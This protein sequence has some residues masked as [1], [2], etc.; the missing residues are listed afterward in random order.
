MNKNGTQSSAEQGA[1]SLFEQKLCFVR[2][3][4][5]VQKIALL[6]AVPK[7]ALELCRL[8]LSPGGRR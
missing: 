6:V 7:K 3:E 5:F 1:P 4:S 8:G 2:Q